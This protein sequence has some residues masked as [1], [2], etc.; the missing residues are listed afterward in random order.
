MNG[1]ESYAFM[2]ETAR[3]LS[4]AM[5]HAQLC[6]LEG[7]RHDVDPKVLA[8]VL[9]EFFT[10]EAAQAINHTSSE[11]HE[12]GARSFKARILR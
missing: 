11:P 6:T 2:Y 12:A 4:K 3:A 10:E 1:G 5:P 9:V 7:Q 8:L